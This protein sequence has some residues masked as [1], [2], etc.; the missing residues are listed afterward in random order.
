MVVAPLRPFVD[1][2]ADRGYLHADYLAY[3]RSVGHHRINHSLAGRGRG[4]CAQTWLAGTVQWPLDHPL[5]CS[6]LERNPS[7]RTDSFGITSFDFMVNCNWWR[8]LFCRCVVPPVR[9]P[10]I[11]Y[12]HLAWLRTYCRA[13]PLLGSCVLRDSNDLI[14]A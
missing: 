13:L 4:H 6:W 2:S 5:S 3:G 11:S 12:C 9:A 14:F 8:V 10:P 1:L 7:L